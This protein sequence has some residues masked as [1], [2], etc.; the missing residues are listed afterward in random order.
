MDTIK[1]YFGIYGDEFLTLLLK[2]QYRA[3]NV[4]GESK[5]AINKYEENMKEY[6]AYSLAHGVEGATTTFFA[7][8]LATAKAEAKKMGLKS[9]QP[10]STTI[11]EK[12]KD[13]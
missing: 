8:N 13:F 10:I 4:C 7:E 5:E 3:A 12:G 6:V 1:L 11:Y 2:N 9:F